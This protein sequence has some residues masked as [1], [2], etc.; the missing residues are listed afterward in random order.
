[1]ARG[2]KLFAEARKTRR[3]STVLVQYGSV[4]EYL[5]IISL[6]RWVECWA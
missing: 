2:R 6:H 3:R 4:K 1:M 5:S